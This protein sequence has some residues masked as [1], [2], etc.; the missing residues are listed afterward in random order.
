M[1]VITRGNVKVQIP[2][3]D[4]Q[5]V[6]NRL[7]ANDFF[8]EMSLLTGEPRTATV[9]AEDEVEVLEIRKGALKP[10]FEANPELMSSVYEIIE[11]RK[12]LLEEQVA[13]DDASTPVKNRGV[14]GSIRRFFG[15]KT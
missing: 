12:L 2:D 6:I 1:F 5:K 13:E 14:L 3:H 7:G 9:V 4:G 10:I 15:I 11:E 8:G